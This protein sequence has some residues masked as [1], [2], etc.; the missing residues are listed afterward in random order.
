MDVNAREGRPESDDGSVAGSFV[1]KE[2]DTATGLINSFS[3][4]MYYQ[5]GFVRI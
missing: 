1:Y 3:K 5:D 4:T 2:S